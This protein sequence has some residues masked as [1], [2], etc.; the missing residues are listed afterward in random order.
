M[1]GDRPKFATLGHTG[2]GLAGTSRGASRKNSHGRTTLHLSKPSKPEHFGAGRGA[3]LEVLDGVRGPDVFFEGRPARK[4][5]P[6]HEVTG[7]VR[8]LEDFEDLTAGFSLGQRYHVFEALPQ[9]F[10]AAWRSSD[11]RGHFYEL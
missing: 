9:F 5:L 10:L 3:T 6:Q 2:V 7:L 8:S 4:A 11:Q 1:H